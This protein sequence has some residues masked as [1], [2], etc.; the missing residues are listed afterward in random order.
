MMFID[1]PGFSQPKKLTSSYRA[2]LFPAMLDDRSI[3][4]P[5]GRGTPTDGS[6]THGAG[7]GNGYFICRVHHQKLRGILGKC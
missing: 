2:V 6:A 7:G 3:Q 4:V 1:F 5:Q